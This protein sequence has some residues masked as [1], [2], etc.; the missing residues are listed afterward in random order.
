MTQSIRVGL[1]GTGFGR[2]VM[3]PAFAACEGAQVVAVC[4]GRRENAEATAK[5]F[6]I[7]GI[8]TDYEAMLD[9]E[10]LNLVV[11][12]TPPHLHWPMSRAALERKLHVLCEKPTA[13]NLAEARLMHQAAQRAGTLNLIDHELRF[14]PTLRKLRSLIAAGFLGAPESVSF[15]IHWGFP[16]VLERTWNWWFDREAGGGL[17]GALGSH[18]FDLLRWLFATEF[19]S[20]NG[21]YHS[22]I[23]ELPLPDSGK[24]A[25]TTDNYCAVMAKLH[26]GALGTIVMDATPK[27]TMER[28]NHTR[29]LSF[30][31]EAGSL[32]FDGADRLWG[33]R[34]E[35]KTEY[36]EPNPATEVSNLPSG[37]FPSGFA[38]F[39]CNI[40]K[41]LQNNTQV[42]DAATFKDGMHIQA[43]ID[44]VHESHR[45][46]A[47]V[48]I[49]A[50]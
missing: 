38:S 28:V 9:Q 10:D 7:P 41:A 44:A 33:V 8:Y 2:R 29:L 37:L 35:E 26:N 3:L 19:K 21:F 15:S 14:Y 18:Q 46:K 17:L 22:F 39:S 5:E 1:V 4:S 31:G 13:M 24:K 23:A 50:F 30:H 6:D 43:V 49:S 11:I 20:V 42:E 12:T 27:M 40:I 48:E 45:R 16:S 47:W 34:G 25:V 36:T 32:I